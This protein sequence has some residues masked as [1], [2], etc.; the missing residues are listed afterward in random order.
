MRSDGALCLYPHMSLS[1]L[2]R[3]LE[4][5]L[6]A[7][8]MSYRFSSVRDFSKIETDQQHGGAIVPIVIPTFCLI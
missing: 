7:S 2:S 8:N 6:K 5:E 3:Y 4:V 1:R